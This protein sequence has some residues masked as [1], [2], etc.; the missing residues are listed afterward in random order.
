VPDSSYFN[1]FNSAGPQRSYAMQQARPTFAGAGWAQNMMGNNLPTA[2]GT[3]AGQSD[4]EVKDQDKTF[5][6]RGTPFD[7]IMGYLS[8][9]GALTKGDSTGQVSISPGG[10]FN[11]MSSQG[12]NI[13]GDPRTKSLGITAPVNVAGNQ[14]TVG[15]QGSFNQYNPYIS[16]RFQF[17]RPAQAPGN[18]EDQFS[19][20]AR[21]FGNQE[22]INTQQAASTVN[23]A[24]GPA[25]QPEVR[26][27]LSARDFLNQKIDEY[28]SSG[29]RDPNSPS[30]WR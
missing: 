30:S 28:R 25:Q 6:S 3:A 20:P 24:L 14:G 26:P 12:L 17:G 27:G 2:L 10:E 7:P 4:R 22:E 11:L 8:G 16:G 21:A 13:A 19:R 15:L 9:A 29:G 1:W 23:A 18:Q 5:Q